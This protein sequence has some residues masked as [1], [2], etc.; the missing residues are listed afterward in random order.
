MIPNVE[1]L[2]IINYKILCEEKAFRLRNW[3]A[4][5]SLQPP[6]FCLC[7]ICCLRCKIHNSKNIVFFF[8][9]FFFCSRFVHSLEACLVQLYGYKQLV[10]EVEGL[11][12]TAY[13][14][15]DLGHEQKLLQLWSLLQPDVHLPTRQT[16]LWQNIGFQGNDPKTDF[17][18]MGLLGLEN[19]L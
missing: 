6:F 13:N 3:S 7:S 12:S 16:K 11:R 1:K 10:Q 17:R 9:L 4:L 2:A 8:C 19:L 14:S 5:Q 15:E 18:G